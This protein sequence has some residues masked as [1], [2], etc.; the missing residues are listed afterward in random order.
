M[1]KFPEIED[2]N[3]DF[4]KNVV[5]SKEN[6]NSI[7]N[8]NFR[9]SNS[10]IYFNDD[11][12]DF[13]Y[14][15]VNKR[16]KSRYIY[17]F[18]T[19]PD[20]FT[21]IVK[22]IIIQEIFYKKNSFSTA[23]QKFNISSKFF[24]RMYKSDIKDILMIDKETIQQYMDECKNSVSPEEIKKTCSYLCDIFELLEDITGY[25]YSS[26]KNLLKEI[27]KELKSTRNALTA[28]NDYI[29]DS[30]LDQTISLAIQDMYNEDL[31]YNDRIVACLLIIMAETG[32]RLEEVSLLESGKLHTINLKSKNKELNYLDFKTFKT[33]NNAGEYKDTYCYLP[34]KATKA[35][36]ICEKLVDEVID[37]LNPYVRMRTLILLSGEGDKLI[38]N[39]GKISSKFKGKIRK[40]YNKIPND[41]IKDA[42]IKARQY[43]FINPV[44]GLPKDNSSTLYRNIKSF[45]IRHKDDI[46]LEKIKKSELK[47]LNQFRFKNKKEYETMLGAKERKKFKYEDVKDNIYYYV[48][49]HRFRVTV[50]TK[51]FQGGVQ[52]DYIVKH[53]NH[54]SE[55]MTVFYNKSNELKDDLDE[56]MKILCCLSKD[57]NGLI[58]T[59]P[60]NIKSETYKGLLSDKIIKESIDRINIFLK[61]NNLNI[62]TDITIVLK[63]LKKFS[64]PVIENE[65]GICINIITQ[66]ICE[67]RAF[68]AHELDYTIALPTYKNLYYTYDL[69]KERKKVVMHNKDIYENDRTYINEYERE[70][71][72]LKHLINTRLAKEINL[73]EIDLEKLGDKVVIKKYPNLDYIIKNISSIKKEIDKWR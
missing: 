64:A 67:K 61:R 42:E 58:E 54:L 46:N 9:I 56:A 35:Y 15:N 69:F 41:K 45:Y 63:K 7:E 23:K 13:N 21:F 19:I 44:N 47:N 25:E 34:V 22:H 66:N 49:P 29:P 4:I 3:V 52:L 43:L 39:E 59:N 18:N 40:I 6:Y 2:S 32:M 73:L 51:L 12:W 57:S 14:L 17:N 20:E 36:R 28:R 62:L 8:E 38:E 37:S 5:K 33:K 10:N 26:V 71:N 31:K 55:D 53:M 27:H 68:F 30:F 50:C 72:A 1:V 70:V 65:L 24:K 16:T 48:N 60:I 11:I